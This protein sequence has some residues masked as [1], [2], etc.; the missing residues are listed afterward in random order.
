MP[1][2]ATV[3][4]VNHKFAELD[5]QAKGRARSWYRDGQL[6]YEWWDSIYDDAIRMAAA[7]GI[8]IGYSVRPGGHR[9]YN[10]WFSG[11]SSQGDGAC[12]EGRYRYKKGALKALKAEAPASYKNPA[13]G[14]L[15]EVPSNQEL[16]RIAK[17]LQEVQRRHFYKLV[18]TSVHSGRY[19]HSGCM[20]VDVEHDEERYRDVGGAEEEVTTL[21]R[22]FADWIYNRLEEEHDW[23][24]SDEQVEESLAANDYT[25]DVDGAPT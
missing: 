10:I 16:H 19:N 23:L 20:S 9:E 2:T 6:D 25:F 18:A 21:L 4:K 15:V 7:I 12:W 14:Y 3:E 8:D 5:E 13:T 1:T 17:A 24:T 11:F 22:D